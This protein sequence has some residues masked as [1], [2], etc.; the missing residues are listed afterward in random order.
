MHG[1][2]GVARRGSGDTTTRITILPVVRLFFSIRVLR[3]NSSVSSLKYR[4]AA[5][6]KI[7]FTEREKVPEKRKTS[8][9]IN[10]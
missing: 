8:S 7:L 2:V 5:L 10:G 6:I 3:V 9:P 4:P 1:A